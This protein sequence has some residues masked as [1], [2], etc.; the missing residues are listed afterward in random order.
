M[1]QN[2]IG[3]MTCALNEA[4]TIA[5]VL[6]PW[7]GKAELVVYVDSGSTDGTWEQVQ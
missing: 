6:E 4:A 5:F 2:R 1:S 3:V 7:L